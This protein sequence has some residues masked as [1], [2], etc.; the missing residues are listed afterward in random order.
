M[1]SDIGHRQL[2]TAIPEKGK[3]NKVSPKTVPP[4]FLMNVSG[5]SAR[6][7]NPKEPSGLTELRKQRY[8]EFV[9]QYLKKKKTVQRERESKLPVKL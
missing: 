5:H 8:L 3:T 2:R 6:R 7:R 4:Y 9:R 1:F